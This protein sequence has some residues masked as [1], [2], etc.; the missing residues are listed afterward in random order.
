MN[1]LRTILSAIA[2]LTAFGLSEAAETV[3]EF[4]GSESRT[5]AE[6]EIRAPWLL[7]WR[8]TSDLAASLAVEVALL[9]GGTRRHV[10]NVLKTKW[11]G[12][13]ARLFEEGGEFMFRVDSTFANWSLRVEQLSRAEAEMYTPVEPAREP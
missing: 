4:S 2:L 11:T 8:V 10:G 9:E 7:E 5:T 12:N 6:F 3:A 13:G 1:G